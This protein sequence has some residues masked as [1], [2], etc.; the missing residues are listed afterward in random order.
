M[1][2]V[3]VRV[4]EKSPV[5]CQERFHLRYGGPQGVGPVSYGLS[6]VVPRSPRS[7]R[8]AG[9]SIPVRALFKPP[10]DARNASTDG[11]VAPTGLG[12]SP[13]VCWGSSLGPSGSHRTVGGTVSVRVF[14]KPPARCQERFHRGYGG[15]QGAG[16]VSCGLSGV[17][18]RA[19]WGPPYRR[20]KR[21]GATVPSVETLS[22]RS[23]QRCNKH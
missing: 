1:E 21:L 19:P 3:P 17:V 8:T 4:F 11:T 14:A 20:W 6:G 22:A 23:M 15:P 9:G 18:P 12:R 2:R 7:H 10:A 13:V 5:R 16:S